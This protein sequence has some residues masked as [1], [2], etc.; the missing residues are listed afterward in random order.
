M[1]KITK[2]SVLNSGDKSYKHAVATGLGAIAD[3]DDV[4]VTDVK[5]FPVGSQYTDLTNKK[6]YVRTAVSA[7]P[8]V[9]DWTLVG[10]AGA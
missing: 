10:P 4:I 1:A 9:A 3:A 6:F 2:L 7:T 5:T 8:A